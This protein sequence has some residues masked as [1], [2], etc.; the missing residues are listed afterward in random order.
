[1]NH[2]SYWQ[3]PA[4]CIFG[5]AAF[6]H[7]TVSEESLG[8]ELLPGPKQQT[9]DVTLG[10][11]KLSERQEFLQNVWTEQLIMKTMAALKHGEK[12]MTSK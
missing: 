8:F 12:K 1:M 5:F 9:D 11:G 2:F 4:S 10:S 6:L 3:D 7:F